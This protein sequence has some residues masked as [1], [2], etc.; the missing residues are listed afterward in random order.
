MIFSLIIF[1]TPSIYTKTIK[2]PTPLKHVKIGWPTPKFLRPTPQLKNECSLTCNWEIS[3]ITNAAV[4]HGWVEDLIKITKDTFG[5][6]L[7][8]KWLI[9]EILI[10]EHMQ[11]SPTQ[12]LFNKERLR[13]RLA[14]MQLQWKGSVW[15]YPNQIWNPN[16]VRV[17]PTKPMTFGS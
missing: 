7:I 8:I 14:H 16:L 10:T 5:S 3:W 2:R 12:P 4:Q 6:H 15:D 9:S 13:G 11:S 1:M 17:H